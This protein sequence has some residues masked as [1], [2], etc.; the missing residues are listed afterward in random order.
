MEYTENDHDLSYSNIRASDYFS[1]HSKLCIMSSSLS[2]IICLCSLTYML[3]IDIGGRCQGFQ[4]ET[5]FIF[6]L[7]D[8]ISS[9]ECFFFSLK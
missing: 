7:I 1:K 4:T 8:M 2:I 6:T 3:I 5:Y 9:V